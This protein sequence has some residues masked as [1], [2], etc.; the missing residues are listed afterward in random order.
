MSA[1]TET[2]VA[3]ISATRKALEVLIEKYNLP[4]EE[5]FTVFSDEFQKELRR[6]GDLMREAIREGKI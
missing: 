3:S 1:T 5:V 6:I 2:I 4:E